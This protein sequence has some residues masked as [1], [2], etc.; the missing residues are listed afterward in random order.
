VVLFTD[1]LV[2]KRGELI[3]VGLDQLAG[4]VRHRQGPTAMCAQL[5]VE[6]SRDLVTDDF[7]I[8]AAAVDLGKRA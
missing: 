6:R 1:G 7:C 4:R 3:D 5:V 8:V 2:E